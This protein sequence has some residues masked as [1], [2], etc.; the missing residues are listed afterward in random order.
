MIW[1]LE[2]AKCIHVLYL[3]S[4]SDMTLI[5]KV[6]LFFSIYKSNMSSSLSS[7]TLCQYSVI[8]WPEFHAFRHS[9]VYGLYSHFVSY[10]VYSFSNVHRK[11][12]LVNAVWVY[13]GICNFYSSI[14]VIGTA[15]ILIWH[16][17]VQTLN[18][19]RKAK[20]SKFITTPLRT[21]M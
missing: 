15:T 17:A 9:M 6:N 11:I 8:S 13:V 18:K 3:Y 7:R 4:V 2:L 19:L 12:K 10:I 21:T 16:Y 20:D 1:T 5:N 14:W